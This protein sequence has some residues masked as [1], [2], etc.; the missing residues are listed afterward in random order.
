MFVLTALL[1]TGEN[2]GSGARVRVYQPQMQL[3]VQ[4]ASKLRAR[5]HHGD[6]GA[7]SMPNPTAFVAHH[8]HPPMY[9]RRS[10][11]LPVL[12]AQAG[13]GSRASLRRSAT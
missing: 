1:V 13:A 11:A 5:Q 2:V 12:V 10:N 4:G 8:L 9:L 7:Y 3:P 6:A